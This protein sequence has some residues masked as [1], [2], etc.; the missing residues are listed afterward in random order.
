MLSLL[1]HFELGK[2]SKYLRTKKLAKLIT[3]SLFVL[4]FIVVSIGIYAFFVSSFRYINIVFEPEFKLPLL[5]FVYETFLLVLAVVI[6]LSSMISGIFNLF[7]GGYNNWIISTPSYKLFPTIISIK[8]ILTSAWPLLVM[9]LPMVLAFNKVYGLGFISLVLLL[10]S[11]LILLL[12]LNALT[13]SVVVG[14]GYIYYLLSQ[15]IKGLRFSFGGLITSLFIVVAIISIFIWKALRNIDLVKIFK[16]DDADAVLKFSSIGNHFT[17]FPTHPFAL[18]II[19]L[20]N[21]ELGSALFNFGI[22]CIITFVS[23]LIW[24]KISELFYT[25]WQKFQEG[26]RKVDTKES[27]M[28]KNRTA[29]HFTGSPTMALFKKE[30]LVSSRDFKGIL[31]FL[32]LMF[33]W[34]IEIGTNLILGDNLRRYSPDVSSQIVIFQTLRFI[35]AVYFI[36]AFTLRFVF[37]SFSVEKKTAWILASAPLDFKK[38]FFGKYLFY[39]I[40]FV[41]IGILMSYINI[42]I[43]NVPFT[44]AFYSILLFISVVIFIVTLGL[45]LGA[46]FPNSE[47][48]DPEV[49][50]TSMPG[51]FFTAF[52][53][54]YGALSDFMLYLTLTKGF[55]SLLLL[56]SV[57][58]LLISMILLA[59]TPELVKNKLS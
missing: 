46:L 36:S 23:L 10:L 16:A 27:A 8:S 14:I 56:F 6:I 9:F 26:S 2:F 40:F 49:I 13:L 37:P 12:L 5:L 21:G 17:S 28:M 7:R 59:K 45:S 15:K 42:I 51:L 54:L 18:E 24:W 29:Y 50:S 48:D 35:A 55:V 43:L 4:V 38:I 32:F 58:T 34:I 41:S 52:A 20:Q 31:W 53:L 3:I 1:L 22:L 11:V 25:M 44:H 30:A 39:T 47:T 19:H 57:F 33:I